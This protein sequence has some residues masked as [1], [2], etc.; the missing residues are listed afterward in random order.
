MKNPSRSGEIPSLSTHPY[1]SRV[2]ITPD[3]VT[4]HLV[5]GARISVPLP[6]F[7]RLMQATPAQ[8]NR[9][10]LVAGGAG[11]SW[12]DINEDL[13]IQGMIQPQRLSQPPRLI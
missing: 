1:A 7:D 2:E 6:Y 10:E 4:A 9:W 11:I 13:S 12:P 3:M 5:S 8:L